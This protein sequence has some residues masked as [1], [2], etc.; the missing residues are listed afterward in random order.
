MKKILY[1][2]LFGVVAALTLFYATVT[3]IK[4]YTDVKM[5]SWIFDGEQVRLIVFTLATMAV[6]MAKGSLTRRR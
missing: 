1:W 2:V 3:I 5:S 6:I 4:A